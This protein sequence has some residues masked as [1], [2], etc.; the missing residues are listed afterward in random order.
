MRYLR[1]L[2]AAGKIRHLGLTNVDL[3][4]LRMLRALDFDITSNQVSVSI[5]DQRVTTTGLGAWCLENAVAILA[6]GV[7]LGGFMSEKWVGKDEPPDE[8]LEN[9][10]LKK[11]KRFIEVAGTLLSLMLPVRA[12]AESPGG[13]KAFQCVLE[14]T[15]KIANKHDVSIAAIA[16]RH[17][18]DVPGVSSVIIGSTLTKSSISRI[19]PLLQA[20]RIKLDEEDQDSIAK[21]QQGLKDIPGG[22]GDEYRKPPFLTAS[23]DLSHHLD[24]RGGVGG[25]EEVERVVR[26]GGRVE[27]SSGSQWEPIAVSWV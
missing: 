18:L 10:S 5:I 24:G 3:L 2:Q 7:L 12:D 14:A 20:F 17:V 26:M 6:Y 11:Y 25:V 13:W 23:G 21:A 8:Q 16:I 9:W 22:C 4:H 19:D 1:D 27:Y 15:R